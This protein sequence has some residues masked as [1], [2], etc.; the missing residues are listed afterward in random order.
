[1][2]RNCAKTPKGFFKPK[3]ETY[4]EKLDRVALLM[5][6][7]QSTR[8]VTLLKTELLTNRGHDRLGRYL[9][10]IW[11]PPDQSG[12]RMICI[13]WLTDFNLAVA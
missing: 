12:I 5:A 7:L 9:I 1:M 2:A 11:Q 10:L 4:S 8:S 6:D 3:I 13:L